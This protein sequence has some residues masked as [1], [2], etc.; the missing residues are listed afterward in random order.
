MPIWFMSSIVGVS[1]KKLEI[2]GVAPT[3]SPAAI[4]SEPFGASLRYQSNHGL[5]KAEPPIPKVGP[6]VSEASLSGISCPW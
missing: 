2:G 3:E 4:V 5:R 6:T 1:P